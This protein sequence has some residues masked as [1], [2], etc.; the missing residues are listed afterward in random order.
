I[1]KDG[2]IID[3]G[4]GYR[5]HPGIDQAGHLKLFCGMAHGKSALAF[6]P[7]NRKI[8]RFSCHY[9]LRPKKLQPSDTAYPRFKSHPSETELERCYT[10]TENE[11]TFC[12]A[13]TRSA[14]RL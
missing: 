11:R 1:G 2:Q 13:Y 5:L 8:E 6:G 12:D 9:E 10:P 7:A 3:T 14:P 4:F